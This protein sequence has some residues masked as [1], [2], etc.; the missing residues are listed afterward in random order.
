MI[1]QMKVSSSKQAAFFT[2][3]TNAC[4]RKLTAQRLIAVTARLPMKRCSLSAALGDRRAVAGSTFFRRRFIEQN[5]F[6]LHDSCQLVTGLALD[7]S[8]RSRQG[9]G[10]PL[11]VIK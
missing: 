9:K 4:Y 2:R 7:V 11:V 3:H 6:A 1:P 8:M 5:S 10:G